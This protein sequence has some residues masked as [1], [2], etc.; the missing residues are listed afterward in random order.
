MVPQRLHK[1]HSSALAAAM[2]PSRRSC[3][4]PSYCPTAAPLLPHC[5]PTAAKLLLKVSD[6]NLS[7]L[8]EDATSSSSMAV[9]NPVGLSAEA[10]LS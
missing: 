10:L 1:H 7:K 8:L 5:C 9:L 6:L 2:R 3:D 4:L